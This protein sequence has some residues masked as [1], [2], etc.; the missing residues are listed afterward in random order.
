[1]VNKTY[2]N[3][4]QNIQKSTISKNRSKGKQYTQFSKNTLTLNY[5]NIVLLIFIEHNKQF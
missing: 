3:G 5:Q 4:K 2:K 1:M